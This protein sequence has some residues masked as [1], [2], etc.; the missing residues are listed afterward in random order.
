LTLA[1]LSPAG[2]TLASAQFT[3][4]PLPFPGVP[5]ATPPP[6]PLQWDS[7]SKEMTVKADDA[8]AKFVFTVTNT[9]DSEVVIDRVQASCQCTVAKVPQPW[10]L[11]AHTNAEMEV[12]VNL[13]GKSGTIFKTITLF[14]T[15]PPNKLLMVKVVIPDSAIT[16][17]GRNQSMAM[18]DRQAVFKNECASCHADKSKGQMGKELY[19]SACANCHDSPNRAVMV[20]DLHTL[21]HP[22]DYEYWKQMIING[23]PGTM[24]PAFATNQGGPLTDEQIESLAKFL[25]KAFPPNAIPNA[26]RLNDGEQHQPMKIS[27]PTIPKINN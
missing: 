10:H 18:A 19:I 27:L 3:P 16:I 24:M 14:S 11:A 2:W 1:A 21:N 25:P 12:T 22:T 9:S 6:E 17:R 7:L 5:P 20:P 15:N 8:A 26:S 4:G 13:A 23:K